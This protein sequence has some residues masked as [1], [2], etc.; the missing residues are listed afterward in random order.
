MPRKFDKKGPKYAIDIIENAISDV[1]GGASI[2]ETARKYSISNSYL[3]KRLIASLNNVITTVQGRH[4]VL[5]DEHEAHIEQCLKRME[6]MGLGPTLSSF[7]EIVR[8]YIIANSIKTA[9][10]DS[11]PGYDWASA[12]LRRHNLTLKKTSMMQIARRNVTADPFVIYGFF[13]LV[14]SEITRLGIEKRPECFWNLDESGFPMDPS[15]FKTIGTI[16][17]KTI[18]VT[19]GAGRE[20]TTVLAVVSANGKAL[21]PFIIFK[22][23]NLR[24]N[25][26]GDESLPNTKYVASD[27]GWMTASIFE[28][29]FKGFVEE[30]KSTRP[31]LLLLDGHLSHTSLNTIDIARTENI[32]ILKLPAHCTDLLQPL[33][34]ACFGPLKSYY[35]KALI[36]YV[37]AT[38]GRAPLQH[39]GFADMLSKVWKKGLSPSN[40]QS[41][42][43][44]TG[45]FPFDPSTYK[46]ERLDKMKLITYDAWLQA[47]S[48]KNDDGTPCLNSLVCRAFTSIECDVAHK[49]DVAHQQEVAQVE[50][51]S[52]I[53]CS[54]EARPPSSLSSKSN[55]SPVALPF[56]SPPTQSFRQRDNSL[57]PPRHTLLYLRNELQ[58]F[59]PPDFEYDIILQPKKIGSTIEEVLH[60]RGRP[61]TS[62]GGGRG[63]KVASQGTVITNQ[64]YRDKIA[65]LYAQKG[66]QNPCKKGQK[67]KI[68]SD[69]TSESSS[70]S[71]SDNESLGKDNDQVEIPVMNDPLYEPRITDESIGKLYAV[72]YT[73]PTLV[74]YWGRVL[75]TFSYDEGGDAESVELKFYHK[76]TLSSEAKQQTWIL[77]ARE[78]VSQVPAKCIFFGPVEEPS[79]RKGIYIFQNDVR[80]IAAFNAVKQKT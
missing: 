25:W 48:P 8:E 72:Y 52:A 13:D 80:A 71:S 59:A 11:R 70:S 49:H 22:G 33:D 37:H 2:R 12:F 4:P 10:P 36:E 69:I 30:T 53:N 62:A 28:N 14:K 1:Q 57:S 46:T 17:K 41:G 65:E 16:G 7:Q 56:S 68:T 15:K 18:R 64:Q 31:I 60:G 40:I 76:K 75:K 26:H 77:P 23:K 38:G 6:A 21:D 19:P 50:I 35:E 24:T 55:F 58:K 67:R 32:S 5:G 79:C 61:G 54:P 20:N 43:R 44:A 51:G 9:F 42:F 47:G 29:F 45:I 78:D 74:Y 73:N 34:V 39:S 63:R 27:N 66:K 3:R